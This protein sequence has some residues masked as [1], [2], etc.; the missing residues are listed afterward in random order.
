MAST[1]SC[2]LPGIVD[3]F[4]SII[5]GPFQSFCWLC[6]MHITGKEI[7]IHI[8]IALLP[9][10]YRFTLIDLG[11]VRHHSDGV[12]SNSAFGKALE[13]GSMA[14]PDPSP[15]H[16]TTAPLV[17]HMIVGD[18]AFPLCNYLLR[19]YPGRNLPGMN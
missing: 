3:L 15:L 5:R 4:I 19:P 2:K 11:E 17:L 16:E 10:C 1:L 14:L 8:S 6:V 18:D 12:F 13:D 9:N 7:N